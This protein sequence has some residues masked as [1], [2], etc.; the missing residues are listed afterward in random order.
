MFTNRGELGGPQRPTPA[1]AKVSGSESEERRGPN[2]GTRQRA[3][4][5]SE[6]GNRCSHHR[7]Q[8]SPSVCLELDGLVAQ[9]LSVTE[10]HAVSAAG[11]DLTAAELFGVEL[12][13]QAAS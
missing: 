1:A 6:H 10:P 12:G 4:L 7:K 13:V 2:G 11:L 9:D 3:A 8:Q 5:S